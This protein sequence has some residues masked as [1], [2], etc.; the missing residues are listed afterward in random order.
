LDTGK[1]TTYDGLGRWKG[2]AKP[3]QSG[4][5]EGGIRRY[6]L[7]RILL[8]G[9]GFLT[10][11]LLNRAMGTTNYGLLSLW[12][13]LASW[14]PQLMVGWMQQSALRYHLTYRQEAA[15]RDYRRTAQVTLQALV[16]LVTLVTL[17]AL[18]LGGTMSAT[19]RLLSVLIA[20]ATV[21]GIYYGAVAQA[22]LKATLVV[23]GDLAR[24]LLPVACFILHWLLFGTLTRAFALFYFLLGF[25]A[26][27]ALL[28]FCLRTPAQ[29]RGTFSP[30]I[31]RKLFA[32]GLPMGVWF[33]LSSGQ[34]LVGRLILEH[35]RLQS[36]L[37]VFASF[38]D[39]FS[40]TGT[41]LFMP[42]T[43]AL[44]G[45]VMALWAQQD[46]AGAI[47]VIRRAVLYQLALA[48]LLLP[49][50]L[51]AEPLLHKILFGGKGVVEPASG[52][53][54]TVLTVAIIL[55]NLGL[56]TH[57]GLELGENTRG[58]ALLMGVALLLNAIVSLVLTPL[59]GTLGVAW[60]ML[61]GNAFYLV[62]TALW[63]R[64]I[65]HRAAKEAV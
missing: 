48:A 55:S 24:N 7:G 15:Y 26:A 14:V 35:C 41:V 29:E 53:F 23:W 17:I 27:D 1:A 25:L 12:L 45:Q 52:L 46:R 6:F 47:H 30:T 50:I 9:F 43:Y 21:S 33:G 3:A 51:V 18:V 20:A 42:V 57:K 49:G 58:M 38:Q 64:H 11:P 32:F 19:E 31:L 37:G 60:G 13:T 65:L 40:K 39:F 44:H 10:I 4:T 2:A 22:E 54:L 56:V 61:A 34:P 5:L 8:A 62:A 63:S 16:V 36:A 28:Y 59:C